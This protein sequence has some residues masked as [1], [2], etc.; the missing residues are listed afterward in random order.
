VPEFR[1]LIEEARGGGG[2]W[3]QVP[4]S[5]VAELGGTARIPVQATFDGIPYRGSVV[6]MGE[7]AMVIGMLKAIK[8]ALGKSTGD[9]VTITLTRDESA[10][11]VEV[12]ADL[13]LALE[14]AGLD[15]LFTGLSF[16]RRKEIAAGVIGAKKPETR[17]RRIAQAVAQ[18]S[19]RGA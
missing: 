16:T 1:G 12:P 6:S 11:D 2:S 3:I 9:E 19:D 10:R 15:Q 7:G 17:Q 14:S 8:L 5:V 18:L 4:P 13:A